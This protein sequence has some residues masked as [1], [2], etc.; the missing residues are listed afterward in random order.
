MAEISLCMIVKNEEHNLADCLNCVTGVVDEINI[1]D[2]GSTDKTVE[3]AKRYTDRI[4][5]FDWIDDFAA[6]RNFSYSKS[7]KS[8]T[9]WLDADDLLTQENRNK[10]LNLKG[11]LNEGIDYVVALYRTHYNDDDSP[12]LIFPKA[13]IT[14][15]AMGILWKGAVHED[16]EIQGKGLTTDLI[17]DHKNKDHTPSMTRDMRIL[18]KEIDSG[19]A[20]YRIHFFYGLALFCDDQLDEAEKYLNMVVETGKTSNFDPIELYV[21]LHNIYKARGDFFKA[22]K[23]L[24]DNEQLMSDKSEFYCCLGLLYKECFNDFE[25]ACNLYK[26]ALHCKGTFLKPNIPGQINPDYYYHIPNGLLGKAY[27]SLKDPDNALM[28]FERALKYKDNNEIKLLTEKLKDLLAL[29]QM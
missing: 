22:R 25:T 15:T 28:Y 29:V 4:F 8:F 9:M 18:K 14:R 24:E 20:D 5:Y 1:I 11:V 7:T 6:A 2:T 13:R 3:I 12:N 23:I 21:A 17:I 27:V 16:L 10:L 26:Q 19:R